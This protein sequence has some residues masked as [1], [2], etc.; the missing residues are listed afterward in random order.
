MILWLNTNASPQ[1][2][3]DSNKSVYR[4][5]VSSQYE[6][7]YAISDFGQ[8]SGTYQNTF[9][10]M[11]GESLSAAPDGK[12][13]W[14]KITLNINKTGTRYRLLNDGINITNQLRDRY[15]NKSGTNSVDLL[16]PEKPGD[17]YRGWSLNISDVFP[18]GFPPNTAE[19]FEI[20]FLDNQ[21]SSF[22]LDV[23]F[24]GWTKQ[25]TTGVIQNYNIVAASIHYESIPDL[26]APTMPLGPPYN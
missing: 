23:Y 15:N 11:N 1:E 16:C 19:R 17:S 18:N 7:S 6:D 21:S 25:T 13:I 8:M 5:T 2:Y 9:V 4:Y 14:Y 26:T 22:P 10:G 20:E 24:I 3:I 12:Y